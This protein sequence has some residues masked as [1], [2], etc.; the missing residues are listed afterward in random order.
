MQRLFKYILYLIVFVLSF[1]I[2]LY[3]SFPYDSLKDRLISGVERQL[4]GRIVVEA[5]ELE[6]YWFTGVEIKNLELNVPDEEG[7]MLSAIVLDKLRIR[8][9]LFSLL[10]GSPRISYL[11]RSG[12]GE[13][14]GSVRQTEEE[15][16]LEAD[17]D[18]FDISV[19]K[20]L[21]TKYGINLSGEIDGSISLNIDARRPARSS[22]KIALDLIDFKVGASEAKIGPMDLPLPDLVLTKSRGSSVVFNMSRGSLLIDKMVFVGGDLGLD[23][24]GKIFLSNT[25]P[26]S[27]FNI[28]GNFSASDALGKTL[29]FLFIIEKQKQPDGTY[30]LLITGRISSPNIKIGS[31]TLPL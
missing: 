4:G 21:Q 18:E 3:W 8:A 30:P 11:I 9:A 5:G 22:G 2:F 15:L 26:N 6:P 25:I 28:K 19:L 20:I 17:F 27:R 24:T 31:F 10:I 13:V 12:E 14:G 1:V 29:P 23:L 16:S 7:N